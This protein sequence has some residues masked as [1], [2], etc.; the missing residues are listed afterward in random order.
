MIYIIFIILLFSAEIIYFRIADHF[1]IIDKPNQR[2]SHSDITL[3]GGGIIF[4]LGVLLYFLIEGFR[5]PWFFV[6]LTIISIISFADD[7][8]HQS[9]KLRLTI[10][11]LAM[12]LLFSQW[13][14][15]SLPWY[16]TLIGLIFCTGILNA[17]NFMDGINGITGGYSL[18]L[19][20][21]L[22]YINHFQIPFV[23][24]ALLNMLLLSVFVFNFFNFRTKAKCFAGDVG[25]VSIAFIIVFLLGL[26]VI[27]THNFSYIVLLSVYGVDS[28]LTILHRLILKENISKPHRKHLF[29]LLANEL[30]IK[31]IAVSGLYML[32]QLIIN[33]GFIFVENKY[34]YLLIVISFLS[35]I[36]VFVKNRFF[37]LHSVK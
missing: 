20:G 23:D 22:W 2:S 7:I 6:G 28:V 26:L 13:N 37:H 34:A 36:Y 33:I 1:N 27:E 21:T 9:K 24:N 10:H 3:R 31:H 25:A 14:L 18:I 30:K 17:Y 16:F 12:I 11:F 5:Y 35:I 29:Q 19:I 32:I 8:T 4:Y 15:F